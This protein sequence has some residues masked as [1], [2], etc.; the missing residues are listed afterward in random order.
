MGN[1]SIFSSDSRR[2][3]RKSRRRVI[4]IL[5]VIGLVLLL[6]N[7]GGGHVVLKYSVSGGFI[8][9]CFDVTIME[10]GLT[11]IQTCDGYR[12][13][14]S[15]IAT[16]HLPWRDTQALRKLVNEFSPNYVSFGQMFV[17]D[18]IYGRGIF[19]GAGTQPLDAEAEG[20][21]DTIYGWV[22]HVCV[23]Q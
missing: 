17:P 5:I 22:L 19:F 10:T 12:A 21:L 13:G 15:R 3:E 23:F 2:S 4:N 14:S 9:F 6:S 18:G 20:F 16:C 11:T 1:D 8:G 7:D